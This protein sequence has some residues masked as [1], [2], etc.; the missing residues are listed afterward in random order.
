MSKTKKAEALV[1]CPDCG[2]NNFTPR[3]MKAH[4]CNVRRSI[5]GLNALTAAE[6]EK[7]SGP[8][9][10]PADGQ[11]GSAVRPENLGPMEAVAFMP[12][13]Q[14]ENYQQINVPGFPGYAVI[15]SQRK[16]NGWYHAGWKTPTGWV[17]P[18]IDREGHMLRIKAVEEALAAISQTWPPKQ[19]KW[20][21]SNDARMV[22]CES[23][24]GEIDGEVISPMGKVVSQDWAL[25][26]MGWQPPEAEPVAKVE[27][28]RRIPSAKRLVDQFAPTEAVVVRDGPQLTIFSD[29]EAAQKVRQL[30]Q[31]AQ[32]GLRRIIVCGLYL[33]TIKADLPHG[34]FGKW[35]E[36]YCPEISRRTISVW[37]SLTSNIREACG[38]KLAA[39][40]NLKSPIYEAI[41]LPPEDRPEEVRDVC[42]RMDE[43]MAGKSARQLLLEFKQAEEDE[44]GNLVA[45]RGRL[46]GSK[47]NRRRKGIQEGLDEAAAESVEFLTNLK[48]DLYLAATGNGITRIP[49]ELLEGLLQNA[50]QLS[51]RIRELLK[52][53]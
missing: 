15:L 28:P 52:S 6:K 10:G 17:C 33:E 50:V 27:K 21:N 1:S 16:Q 53:H 46:P 39:A 3:G 42:A 7:A 25:R 11:E 40:A 14:L 41:T 19:R 44:D 31:D 47:S 18:T 49:R 9:D 34:Q 51:T 43:L 4:K 8:A 22:I 20:A 23:S 30:V 36:T 24:P 26:E 48:G 5:N 2:R 38:I 37:M 32:D 45:R 12:E 29:Q 13:T 35:L